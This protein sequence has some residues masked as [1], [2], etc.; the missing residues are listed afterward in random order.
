MR[1]KQASR[2]LCLLPRV[3]LNS[4]ARGHDHETAV[5]TPNFVASTGFN[6]LLN[7]HTT[8]FKALDAALDAALASVIVATQY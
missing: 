2:A 7:R 4:Q 6:G 5:W 3:T 8:D 1:A